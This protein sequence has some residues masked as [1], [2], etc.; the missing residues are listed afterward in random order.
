MGCSEDELSK[1]YLAFWQGTFGSL[2]NS[3][4]SEVPLTM[5]CYGHGPC[6]LRRQDVP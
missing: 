2:G 4:F 6:G 5:L 3:V 1:G